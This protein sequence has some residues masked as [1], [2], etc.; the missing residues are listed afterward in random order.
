[1]DLTHLLLALLSV[2]TVVI[3]VVEQR[4]ARRSQ[5]HLAAIMERIDQNQA[6]LAEHTRHTAEL[7]A[8]AAQTAARNGQ[9]TMA[10]LQQFHVQGHH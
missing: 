7:A 10:V 4:S 2:A 3:I 6:R 5:E 1:M 9:L 8:I